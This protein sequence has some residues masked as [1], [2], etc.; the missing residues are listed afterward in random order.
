MLD[1]VAMYNQIVNN[2]MSQIPGG[3]GLMHQAARQEGMSHSIESADNA[4]AG[5]IAS[6]QAQ[7]SALGTNLT[8]FD[9]VLRLFTEGTATDDPTRQTIY[10][11]IAAAAERYN[12]DPN[13]IRAVMQVESNFDPDAVSRAGAMGLMQLMPATATYLGVQNPFDIVQNIN[14]GA[15]YLRQMLDLFDGD[16]TLALAAYNA[17]PGAVTRHGGIPPFAETIAYVPRVQDF[18]D[19]FILHQYAEAVRS[20][21]LGR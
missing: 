12:L 21:S 6:A 16:E 7:L 11:A 17:G 9:D 3:Q 2:I 20:G 4:G 1:A 5:L 15:R 18:R 10:D 8:S 14:G 19:Q 13:L